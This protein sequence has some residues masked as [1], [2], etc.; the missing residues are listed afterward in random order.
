MDRINNIKLDAL[1]NGACDKICEV[2]D[3]ASLVK[4][5]FSPQGREFC[6]K[7][8]FP[9][10]EY[11]KAIAKDVKPYNVFVD[12]SYLELY[13]RPY[14]AL[15][16]KTHARVV[17]RGVDTVYTII[18]MHGASAVIDAGHYA[19]VKIV[20]ISGGDVTIHND[21]TAKIL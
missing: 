12:M 17:A 9:T 10:L 4:L 11:F 21:K 14:V 7:N 1:N 13:N 15:V 20:N 6:E 2:T 19:V 8:N 18:L 3:Y 16:G 5:F